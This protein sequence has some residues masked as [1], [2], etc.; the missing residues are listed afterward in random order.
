MRYSQHDPASRPVR[1]GSLRPALPH[2]LG[3]G[4]AVTRCRICQ[5]RAPAF[6][7]VCNAYPCSLIAHDPCAPADV[8]TLSWRVVIRN[9]IAAETVDWVPVRGLPDSRRAFVLA[10]T[11]TIAEAVIQN[12]EPMRRVA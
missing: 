5:M 6:Q 7:G 11:L 12:L 10:R 8:V 4:D 9:I 3:L 2:R 1:L